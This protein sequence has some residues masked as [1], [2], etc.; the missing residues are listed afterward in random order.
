MSVGHVGSV[1]QGFLERHFSLPQTSPLR[2]N[3]GQISISC[4]EEMKGK[5][6]LK[7]KR[8]VRGLLAGYREKVGGVQMLAVKMSCSFITEDH[9]KEH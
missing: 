7:K 4:K 9:C 5:L 1:F 3:V 6:K 8:E 2:Q